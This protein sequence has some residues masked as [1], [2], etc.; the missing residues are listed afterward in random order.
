[1]GIAKGAGRASREP[2]EY[3]IVVRGELRLDPA[4][5]FENLSVQPAGDC[6][7]IEGPIMDQSQLHGVLEHL[8]DMGVEIVSVTPMGESDETPAGSRP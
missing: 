7:V 5:V 6:S 8:G 2:I 4:G 1:M 3:R